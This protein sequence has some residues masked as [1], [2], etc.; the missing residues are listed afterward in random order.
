M[1]STIPLHETQFTQFRLPTV[2]RNLFQQHR[3]DGKHS[4]E[5]KSILRLNASTSTNSEIPR[6]QIFQFPRAGRSPNSCAQFQEMF[7][8]KEDESLC[9]K[10][11]GVVLDEGEESFY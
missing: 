7:S 6:Q 1:D 9:T 8:N 3:N 5:S 2:C 10:T 4:H 11:L